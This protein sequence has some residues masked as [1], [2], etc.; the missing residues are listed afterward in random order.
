MTFIGGELLSQ[1]SEH[2]LKCEI[3][4]ETLRSCG[5]LRLRLT[6]HSMLP[7]IWPGDTVEVEQRS[8]AAIVPGDVVLYCRQR[9]LFAHRVLRIIDSKENTRLTVQGDALPE[10]D[11]PVFPVEVLGCVAGI[12]R[13]DQSIH[14][15]AIPTLPTW[16]VARIL[17]HSAS[18]SR[19]L[20]HLRTNRS[21]SAEREDFCQL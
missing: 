11:A 7:A 17:R 10:P 13:S 20:V 4:A 2:A 5:R 15:L 9:R 3:A 21:N 16:C 18:F 14:P 12:V 19:L 6:G 1:E 8:F